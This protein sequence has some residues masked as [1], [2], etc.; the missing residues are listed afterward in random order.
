MKD[1][2]KNPILYYILIPVIVGLWPL[3]VWTV[4][5]PRA[6]Q[7]WQDE[8]KQFSKAEEIIE[9]ILDIDPDRLDFANAKTD[10][11]E[12]DYTNAIDKVA[13]QFRIPATN[14]K[15]SSRPTITSG[16]QKSQRAQVVLKEVDIVRF[17]KFLSTLQ[18]R[19][20]NLQ[21]VKVKLTKKKGLPDAWKVDLD[22]QYYY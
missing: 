22:F 19:W 9:G 4:Y 11:A 15:V 6:K 14:Y 5:L 2:Y 12:F 10:A 17:A 13:G 7:N 3:L 8:K 18:F 1:I 21:C 20:A 16:G